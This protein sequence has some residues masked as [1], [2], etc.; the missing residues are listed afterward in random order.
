[1]PGHTPGTLSFLFGFKD[2]GK[3]LNVAYVGGTAI[4]FDGTG[5]ALRRLPGVR[6]AKFAKAATDFGA[7]VLMSNHTEFDNG[8]F[9][10]I[11]DAARKPGDPNAYEVGK[12]AVTNYFQVVQLCTQA[13][14]LRATGKV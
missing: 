3:T 9:R 13:A 8:Y 2:A 10:A 14:K 11:A 12:Q 1:M 5:R 6:A 4:P 7:T